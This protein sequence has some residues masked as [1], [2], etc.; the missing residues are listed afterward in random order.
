MA[1]AELV[2][3][4]TPITWRDSG[5]TYGITLSS[6]A[7]GAARIGARGDLSAYPN[8][9]MY[10]WSFQTQWVATPTQYRGADI[11][12]VPWDDDATPGIAFGNIGATDAAGTI[13]D[14]FNLIYAG[15]VRVS[16][17]VTTPM[18]SGGLIELPYRYVSPFIYNDGNAA[19]AASGT[20]ASILTLTPV[21]REGQ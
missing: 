13:T 15:S 7:N 16:A 8:P 19:F 6:L 20:F 5:G 3:I 1:S 18:I 2:Q 10:R 11:F 21:Y 17:A 12:F 9:F 14:R 4:G